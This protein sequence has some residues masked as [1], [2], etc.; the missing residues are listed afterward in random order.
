MVVVQ[1]KPVESSDGYLTCH[2]FS[3]EDAA[4]HLTASDLN[5]LMGFKSL[6]SNLEDRLVAYLKPKNNFK[7][8]E[9]AIFA[10]FVS[11]RIL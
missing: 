4:A 8:V 11:L 9:W 2:V 10:N 6:K 1:S 5:V 7:G 3:L